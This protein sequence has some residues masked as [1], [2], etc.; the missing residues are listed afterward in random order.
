[1]KPFRFRLAALLDIRKHA[2][3]QQQARLAEALDAETA[4]GEQISQLAAELAAARQTLGLG[5]LAIAKLQESARW[6]SAVEARRQVLEERQ[7]Q[8]AAEV[9]HCRAAVLDADREVR[10]LENLRETQRQRWRGA[11]ELQAS[12]E[13]D[14]AGLMRHRM[15]L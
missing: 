5:P 6:S 9:E 2:R 4:V 11:A 13:L 7:E 15:S 1:M 14:E 8:L 10:R 12:K 3:T